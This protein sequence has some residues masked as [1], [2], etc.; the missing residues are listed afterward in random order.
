LDDGVIDTFGL[1]GP[2]NG[3]LGN[4]DTNYPLRMLEQN[5]ATKIKIASNAEWSGVI[6]MH[7]DRVD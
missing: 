4:F 1:V 6:T 7:T 2:G 5:I 3:T